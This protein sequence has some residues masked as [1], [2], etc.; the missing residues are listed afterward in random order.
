MPIKFIGTVL[1]IF[2]ATYIGFDGAHGLLKR[3]RNLNDIKT[4][5][6][7]LESEIVFSSRRLREAL[8]KIAEISPCGK[9][10]SD[11]AEFMPDMGIERAWQEATEKNAKKFHLKKRDVEILK[12]LSSRLGMSDKE[13]Q[14][15]NI[16]HVETLLESAISE[17]EEE[18]RNSARLYRGMGFLCGLFAAVI[19]F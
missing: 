14:I 15:K 1:L 4:A 17:A 12:I 9:I 5:I 19:L 11:A 7:I 10:F 8:L 3:E 16:R 13:Q 18:Y 2:A 6:N